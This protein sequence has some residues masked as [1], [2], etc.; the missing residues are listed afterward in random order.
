MPGI[1]ASWG[2]RVREEFFMVGNERDWLLTRT[3]SKESGTDST[4]GL[5]TL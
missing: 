2:E 4:L 3:T 1:I 5:L